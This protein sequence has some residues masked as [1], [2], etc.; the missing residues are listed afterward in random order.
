[1][2]ATAIADR[3]HCRPT[4]VA[5]ALSDIAGMSYVAY[6]VL[7]PLKFTIFISEF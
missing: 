4:K 3:I 5:S 6:I 2:V 7:D 1:M